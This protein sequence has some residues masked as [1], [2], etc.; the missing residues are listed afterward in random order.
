[1][2][3]CARARGEKK[4][5]ESADFSSGEYCVRVRWNYTAVGGRAL[6]AWRIIMQSAPTC[7]DKI[8]FDS[9]PRSSADYI[10]MWRFYSTRSHLWKQNTHRK[11]SLRLLLWLWL[12]IYVDY[13]SFLSD[14]ELDINLLVIIIRIG[15]ILVEYSCKFCQTKYQYSLLKYFILQL[16]IYIV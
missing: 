1:M 15:G 4:L 11:S 10:F 5:Y 2:S 14:L 13:M 9:T 12:D 7:A 3:V 16:N 8:I 6:A